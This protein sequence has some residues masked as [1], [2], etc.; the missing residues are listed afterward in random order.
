M[1]EAESRYPFY[2]AR[3]VV[4]ELGRQHGEQASEKIRGFLDYLAAQLKLSPSGLRRRAERF[5]P[6]FERHCPHLLLEIDG[7]AAGA[8]ITPSDALAVQLR[9]ELGPVG[10]GA[11]TTFVAGRQATANGQTL[12][13]QNS[14]NPVELMDYAYVLR[15]VPEIGP[16]MLMWSFGGMIGYHGVS[17]RGMAHFANSLGGGPAWKFA[18]S[19]Y[20]IKR[21]ILES[22]TLADVRD[23]FSK[24]PVCSNGNYVLCDGEGRFAD[25]ELTSEGPIEVGDE[26]EGFLAHSNHYV[27]GP[28]AC[29]ANFAQSLPDS[30][31]RLDRMNRLLRERLGS[32]D[33]ATMKTILSD[34]EGHP[35]G[36][37]RHP[38]RGADHPSIPATGRTVASLIAEPDRGVL[39]VCRGNPCESPFTAYSLFE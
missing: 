8:G 10:D 34:H 24:F 29:E 4:F 16:R 28:M 11:C 39:H 2:E 9:G 36:L 37:C 35:T 33:V 22:R 3:G 20:P 26:S 15:L 13:G 6:L 14:D 19:H 1:P 25:I 30:F 5:R 32:L 21:L 27:C 18:L 38:H 7:L 23:L 12:I 17:E 31:G